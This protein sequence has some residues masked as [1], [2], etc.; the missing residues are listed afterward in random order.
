MRLASAFLRSPL[1]WALAL[2][3]LLPATGLQSA[4]AAH[5]PAARPALPAPAQRVAAG[6]VLKATT[7]ADWREPSVAHTLY[8]DLPRGRVVIELAPNFAPLHVQNILDLVDD[9]YFKSS[10]VLR[11]HENY[12]VQ[13]GAPEDEDAKQV[14]GLKKAKAE[15]AD[16]ELYVKPSA[17]TRITSI[18]DGDAFAPVA[19]MSGGFPAAADPKAGQTW[20]THCY[21]M[22]GIGRGEAANSGNGSSM[23]VV[24]GHAPRNL[25]RN[26]AVVGRVLQGMELLTSLPRG[27][28]ELGFYAEPS[29]QVPIQI[30]RAADVPEAE[31]TPLEVL[32]TEGQAYQRW[33]QARRYPAS[34]WYVQ[35]PGRVDLCA[36]LPP[37]RKKSP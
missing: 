37:V 12:V 5:A 4:L 32:R 16:G 11:V 35:D 27:T 17:A 2:S 10:A 33:L 24:I 34:T 31:R 29:Q 15:I 20:L 9:G 6:D 7:A 23:Y 25:D 14:K 26:V 22:V 8:M 36:A 18:A 28:A 19:G 30:R 3:G 1:S 13:W 21:S